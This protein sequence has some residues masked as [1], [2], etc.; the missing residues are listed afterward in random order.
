[1]STENLTIPIAVCGL[2]MRGFALE[3]Q[4]QG[5]GAVFLRE[6]ATAPRYRMVK[7]PTVPAKPGLIKLPSGGGSIQLEVW[8]M[9]LA[10]LGSFTAGIP[11]PL[12]IGKIELYDGT[13]VVGFICEGYAAELPGAE[14]VTESGGWRNVV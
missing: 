10:R 3:K 1:M 9:P 7:L 6:A 4:M 8:E 2:H 11:S 12:G 5:H 14:D 13:E